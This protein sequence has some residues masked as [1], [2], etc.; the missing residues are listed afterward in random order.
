ML[1]A[2]MK[3]NQEYTLEIYDYKRKYGYDLVQMGG[4]VLT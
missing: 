2:W 1:Y 3:I 4:E